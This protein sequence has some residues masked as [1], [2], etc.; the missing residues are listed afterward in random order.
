MSWDF[1]AIQAAGWIQTVDF[2]DELGS[3]N[4][5]AIGTASDSRPHPRLVV[6][7]HQQAGRGRGGNRWWA[8]PGALTFSVVIEPH[9]I[10]IP[11]DRWPTLSVAIG[12]AICE[13]IAPCNASPAKHFD[14]GRRDTVQRC[15]AQRTQ[16]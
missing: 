13:A 11:M 3:T 15:F 12:G 2:F 1:G 10:G 7:D 16:E 14:L 4:D 5:Y 6:C 8:N 9:A